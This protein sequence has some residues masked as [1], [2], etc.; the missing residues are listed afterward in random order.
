MSPQTPYAPAR[1]LERAEPLSPRVAGPSTSKVLASGP[2]FLWPASVPAGPATQAEDIG[3]VSA[4]ETKSKFAYLKS[5]RA[6]TSRWTCEV[7]S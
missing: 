3:I 5:S 2:P 7:P 6:M 4:P 1:G